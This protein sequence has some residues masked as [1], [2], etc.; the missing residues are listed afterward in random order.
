MTRVMNAK[1]SAWVKTAMTVVASGCLACLLLLAGLVALFRPSPARFKP[2]PGWL[3]PV[4]GGGME[5]RLLPAVSRLATDYRAWCGESLEP[6]LRLY[7]VTLFDAWR[8]TDYHHEVRFGETPLGRSP[9]T[10]ISFRYDSPE[11]GRF[12]LR[13]HAPGQQEI[14]LLKVGAKPLRVLVEVGADHSL[15]IVAIEGIEAFQTLVATR[16]MATP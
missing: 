12:R 13:L 9:F 6:R 4:V 5:V 7:E 16:P 11:L 1:A 2:G 8:Q 3:P 10:D 14:S 15:H